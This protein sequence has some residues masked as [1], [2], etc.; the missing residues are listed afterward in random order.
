M[1]SDKLLS[2]ATIAATLGAGTCIATMIFN[3][4]KN[5]A[6]AALRA[7]ASTSIAYRVDKRD[8]PASQLC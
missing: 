1:N 7:D 5:D 4:P 8:F 6:L 3:V 2:I